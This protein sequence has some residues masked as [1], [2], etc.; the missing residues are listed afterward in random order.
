VIGIDE[1]KDVD[2]A[3]DA[4]LFALAA[5]VEHRLAT[6]PSA[7]SAQCDIAAAYGLPLS[8]VLRWSLDDQATAL[9][10][11]THQRNT[12]AKTCPSCGTHEGLW[13]RDREHDDGRDP[14][15]AVLHSCRGCRL[16]SEKGDQLQDDERGYLHPRLVPPSEVVDGT[17]WW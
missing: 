8:A 6:G 9:G 3:T 2:L 11:L 14:L 7:F 17:E 16:L 4:T 10:H 5:A 15:V 12:A 1:T 13:D